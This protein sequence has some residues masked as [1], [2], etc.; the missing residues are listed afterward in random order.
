MRKVGDS[1]HLSLKERRAWQGPY[2]AK[3]NAAEFGSGQISHFVEADFVNTS[4]PRAGAD[5]LKINVPIEL[6]RRLIYFHA[7]TRT[8][9][10]PPVNHYVRGYISLKRSGREVGQLP[11]SVARDIPDTDGTGELLV[12]STARI[13]G[14][15]PNALSVQ[16]PRSFE[17]DRLT[18]G[19]F[20]IDGDFD[21]IT[22]NISQV[23]AR[24][25][26]VS[27]VRVYMACLSLKKNVGES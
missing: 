8:S 27:G 10:Q 12:D 3:R 1:G 25:G 5:L 9:V 23:K 11:A 21:E 24:S 19:P 6:T 18:I 22:Y 15:G 4:S 17:N 13:V 16:L 2:D 26:T 14:Q 20:E 7:E